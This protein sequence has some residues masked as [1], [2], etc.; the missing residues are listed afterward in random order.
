[1]QEALALRLAVRPEPREAAV[2]VVLIAG[3][4]EPTGCLRGG[5][6]GAEGMLCENIVLLHATLP[7]LTQRA[8][9]KASSLPV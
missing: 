9:R 1:M 6:H 3:L 2:E 8:E 4:R 5:H 7:L